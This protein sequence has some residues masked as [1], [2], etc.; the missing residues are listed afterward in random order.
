[1]QSQVQAGSVAWMSNQP[2]VP[3]T[4]PNTWVVDFVNTAVN[5]TVKTWLDLMNNQQPTPA[6]IVQTTQTQVEPVQQQPQANIQVTKKQ[7]VNKSLPNTTTIQQPQ[8]WDISWNIKRIDTTDTSWDIKVKKWFFQ[9][10][11]EKS[12][13]VQDWQILNQDQVDNYT[14]KR[15]S[16]VISNLANN[17]Q[18]VDQE[19]LNQIFDT[20]LSVIGVKPWTPE[21]MKTLQNVQWMYLQNAKNAWYN[22]IDE[23]LQWLNKKYNDFAT[24]K[25]LWSDKIYNSYDSYTP[26]QKEFMSQ[27]NPVEYAKAKQKYEEAQKTKSYN[28]RMT[29]KTTTSSVE[30]EKEATKA[31]VSSLNPSSKATQD[32][33]S[34]INTQEL[35]EAEKWLTKY[36]EEIATL[37]KQ[38][39]P[40]TLKKDIMSR[41]GTALSSSALDALYYDEANDRQNSLKSLVAQKEMAMDN[42][43]R[44]RDENMQRYENVKKNEDQIISTL[45]ANWWAWLASSS[46]SDIDQYVKDWYMTEAMASTLKKQ[47][48]GMTIKTMGDYGIVDQSTVKKINQM[49]KQWMSPNAIMMS[50]MESGMYLPPSKDIKE[51]KMVWDDKW[52]NILNW[53]VVSIWSTE[54]MAQSLWTSPDALKILS[55]LNDI[56]YRQ[57]WWITYGKNKNSDWSPRKLWC[58]E[59]TGDLVEKAWFERPKRGTMSIQQKLASKWNN[60]DPKKVAPWMVVMTKLT[61][62]WDGAFYGHALM[63]TSVN[64]DWSVNTVEA[65]RDGKWTVQT[66]VL[67]KNKIM[68]VY[69]PT[70]GKSSQQWWDTRYNNVL[71]NNILWFKKTWPQQQIFKEWFSWLW[72]D[73][74]AQ[75][76]YL[77]QQY[78]ETLPTETKKQL[79]QFDTTSSTAETTLDI[80]YW[81]KVQWT[82]LSTS[83]WDKIWRTA[84]DVTAFFWWTLEDSTKKYRQLRASIDASQAD[85]RNSLFWASLTPW[86]QA[87]ADTFIVSKWD[88]IDTVISK[89]EWQKKTASIMRENLIKKKLWLPVE[90][91]IQP[92]WNDT[93]WWQ[94]TISQP[95]WW[96]WKPNFSISY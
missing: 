41:Y 21:Y 10:S 68:G 12:W 22:T 52:L 89:L 28:D 17:W 51:V 81:A 32:Y 90:K 80:L 30:T 29:G 3:T 8:Q 67:P 16:D 44:I 82:S 34:Y 74:E 61:D 36:D 45:F 79:E 25:N 63:V 87:S 78:I 53:E 69:D 6:P 71:Y 88:T 96:Q 91:N 85:Y 9:N 15:A 64:P 83:I 49:S 56:S 40:Q 58:F 43:K 5:P 46:T 59:F 86:E 60:T 1:M 93:I 23:S 72:W 92:F 26:E 27:N 33:D 54:Q 4:I 38:L 14:L 13:M 42:Y 11:A 73:S 70:R 76:R 20:T 95:T 19:R 84:D 62:T 94:Q 24:L 2:Q 55:W 47:L 50:L 39:D 7:K 77:E 31:Q 65:N 18:K 75:Q 66:A 37:Q 57:S 48:S 35:Q